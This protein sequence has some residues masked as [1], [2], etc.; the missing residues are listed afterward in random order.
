MRLGVDWGRTGHLFAAARLQL[1]TSQV[2]TWGKDFVSL[3]RSWSFCMCSSSRLYFVVCI[4]DV[5]LA[6]GVVPS[7]NGRGGAMDV[8]HGDV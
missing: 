2:T 4:V 8:K 5:C 3:Y 6:H 7:L 1:F